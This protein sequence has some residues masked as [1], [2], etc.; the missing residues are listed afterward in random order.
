MERPPEPQLGI[1]LTSGSTTSKDWDFEWRA[2]TWL[3]AYGEEERRDTGRTTVWGEESW[4]MVPAM[5]NLG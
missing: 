1:A 5:V 2:L 4:A 3:P